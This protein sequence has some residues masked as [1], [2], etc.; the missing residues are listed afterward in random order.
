MFEIHDERG[1]GLVGVA[2]L[3]GELFGDGDVLVPAAVEELDETHAALG[4]AAGEQAVGGVGAGLAGLRAVE[5]EGGGGFA[6]EVGEFGHGG[7]HAE[8]HLVGM[9]AGDGFRI[10]DFVGEALV[11]RGEVVELASGVVR[12]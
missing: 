3:V 6:G 7:L 2:A 12:G 5:I 4:E 10:A 11:E 1:G 9:D 8:G